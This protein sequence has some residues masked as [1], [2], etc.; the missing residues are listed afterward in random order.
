M[1]DSQ[2][3]NN[4]GLDRPSEYRGFTL[5][6][7]LVVIAIIAILAA[8]L[9]PALAQA[10]QKAQGIQCVSNQRQLSL[11]WHMYADDNHESLILSSDNGSSAV[12]PYV[13]SNSGVDTP[14]NYAW[15][16]S[17]LDFTS[18][19]WNW[20]PQADIT[21]RPLWQYMK[22]AGIYHCPA[23][24]STVAVKGVVTPRIRTISMNLFL[25]GF[26]DNNTPIPT[27]ASTSYLP[28]Y[29]KTT[30]LVGSRSPGPASTFVFIDERQDA[31]NW[32]N[33]CTDM[34][35]YPTPA[36]PRSDPG[37]YEWAEDL[38]ASYHHRSAGI[39][40]ADGHAQ[41][42][43]W[44]VPDTMPPLNSITQFA[45]WPVPNSPDVAYMQSVTARPH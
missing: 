6:E 41:L 9:L 5:I 3:F 15:T 8:M 10:K 38:P 21:L 1:T 4:A 40:F 32:G 37:A 16:W 24:T 33:F 35:G 18:N 23:D 36:N 39:S 19:P 42:H 17:H 43:R 44:L 30:D 28:Y 7:L 45:I 2:D 20:D 34:T 12:Q 22:N 31:I 26:G 27:W 11:A 14:N 13:T 29:I 25:G